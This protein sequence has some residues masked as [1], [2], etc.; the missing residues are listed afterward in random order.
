MYKCPRGTV[1]NPLT[2]GGGLIDPP[3]FQRP[4]ILKFLFCEK[5][6]ILPNPLLG[7]FLDN[8]I[9]VFLQ[10]HLICLQFVFEKSFPESGGS[11]D[12]CQV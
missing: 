6:E 5:I 11:K 10:K 1:F 9:F 3:L 7:P 4:R 2:Y 8:Y 12:G